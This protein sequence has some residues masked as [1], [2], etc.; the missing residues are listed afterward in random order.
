MEAFSPLF[1]YTYMGF[2]MYSMMPVVSLPQNKYMQQEE[3]L[4]H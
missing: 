2:I 1:S 3:S 4:S